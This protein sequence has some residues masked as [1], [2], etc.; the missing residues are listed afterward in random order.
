MRCQ[1]TVIHDPSINSSSSSSTS[2]YGDDVITVEVNK[3]D[4]RNNHVYILVYKTVCY[5]LFRAGGP[6]A[7]LVVLNYRL[8]TTLRHQKRWRRSRQTL[9]TSRVSAGQRENVT[10]MLVTVV[11][12]FIICE[13][14]D[15]A[16]RL[17]Y[18]SVRLTSHPSD[19][20]LLTLRYVNA[21]TN[22]LLAFNSSI[23][24]VIYLLVGRTFRRVFISSLGCRSGRYRQ[25]SVINAAAA[26]K[27][28]YVSTTTLR[29][30]HISVAKET[31]TRF[32]LVATDDANATDVPNTE[33]GYDMSDSVVPR[34]AVTSQCYH[35]DDREHVTV[36]L[37]DVER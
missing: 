13:L 34:N 2:N 7:T 29:R 37:V 28:S 15:P 6:L 21:I 19:D 18:A 33:L 12:V 26:D 17:V 30:R 35:D 3:T 1:V 32:M 20:L 11:T 22:A 25:T 5:L 23:N 31:E 9:T 16:L 4:L 24:F 8:F 36:V 14:P 27:A 10:A